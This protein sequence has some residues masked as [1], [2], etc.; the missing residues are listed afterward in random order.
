M[1]SATLLFL[2]L[3]IGLLLFTNAGNNP[4][5]KAADGGQADYSRSPYFM[6]YNAPVRTP[7][8]MQSLAPV[9]ALMPATATPSHGSASG[10]SGFSA[11][12]V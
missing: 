9:V 2:I 12:I 6:R 10:F 11:R 4:D 8:N 5:T 1:P 7:Q 3:V